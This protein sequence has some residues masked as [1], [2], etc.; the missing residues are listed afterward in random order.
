MKKIVCTSSIARLLCVPFL[1]LAVLAGPVLAQGVP[2]P[3]KFQ[4]LVATAKSQIKT[5]D[6]ETFKA[7]LDKNE[8]GLVIDVREPGEFAEG[9]VAG[10][11]NV[12]RGLIE[13]K[14]WP[15][16]GFPD[17]TDMNK[18]LTVYCGT[19]A[20]CVLATKSLQDLGFTNATAVTMTIIDWEVAGYKL[21]QK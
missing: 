13:L 17:K 21:V 6:M 5:I 14:I 15:L 11:I 20:R 4:Q 9:H 8:A 7:R 2:V 12:P 1:A 10:A 3:P 18:Q 19:G 16:V